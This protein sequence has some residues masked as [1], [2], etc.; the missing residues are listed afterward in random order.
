MKFFLKLCTNILLIWI[1]SATG[2]CQ[3]KII[4]DSI[5][6]LLLSIDDN[7]AKVDT[8][9]SLAGK[10][11]NNNP[12]LALKYSFT[13]QK[14]AAEIEYSAGFLE[15]FYAI[16][17]IYKTKGQL[18]SARIFIQK[19][20]NISEESH[21][22]LE[23]GRGFFQLGN[24]L[25]RQGETDRAVQNYMKAKLL[26]QQIG[27]QKQLI[28]ISNALGITFKNSSD[29]DSAAYYYMQ[30]LKLCE[31]YN[32]R[33]GIG[34]TMIN[35][36][37]MHY[38]LKDYD[39]ARNYSLKSI[40]YSKEV[41]NL[42][43]VALAYTN[44]GL[45]EAAQNNYDSAM[46]YY[47]KALAL[48][49]KIKNVL[50]QNNVFINQGDIFIAKKQYLLALEK[51]NEAL[52][53]HK[54][55]GYTEGKL[56]AL[57]SKGGVL[58][59]LGKYR[60]AETLLDSALSI[61]KAMG[62]LQIQQ[63]IYRNIIENWT[64]QKKYENAF[65]NLIL[66]NKLKDSIVSQEE[67][68]NITKLRLNYEKEKDQARILALTN[69]NLEKDLQIRK[70]TNQRNIYLFISAGII[71]IAVFVLIFLRIK[72]RNDNLMAM[73]KIRQLEKDKKLISAQFILEGQE[74]ERKRIA[75]E[76]H[77]G[78]G[79]LLSTAKM[80]FSSIDGISPDSKPKI[81]NATKLLEM[82]AT[83]VRKITHNMMPG[84][85]SKYGFF[86]AIDD[87]IEQINETDTIK[88]E[89]TVEGTD[90]RFP[91]RK[92]FM[93]YRI[94]QEMI[95]NTIKHA[96]ASEVVLKIKTEDGNLFLEYSDNGKGFNVEEKIDQKSIGL[97][98]IKS[99]SEYL[100]G[101][102]NIMSSPGNGTTFKLKVSIK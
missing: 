93:L 38:H 98:S 99:R 23:M 3:Q 90:E 76:L 36:G 84:L 100:G 25:R 68:N 75:K 29:Y 14:Q 88:A 4:Q 43:H 9:L 67:Q 63:D 78:I 79:V 51:Y 8:L 59:K 58:S 82:A 52:L 81:N 72:S 18:D 2:L 30:T 20:I 34:A 85:L 74:E 66:Q 17:K 96:E 60:E 54:E 16:S 91:E 49:I 48:Y 15:S 27:D 86:E 7:Q 6:N 33:N 55:I 5:A 94:V 57:Y 35:L 37:K 70:R 28:Y 19:H 101:K 45:I 80:Q 61:A 10:F 39:L 26:F 92:E 83:E 69:E 53:A 21:D 64:L 11:A 102:I 1:V 22:S 44:L 62:I 47:D 24:I 65:E 95:N 97:T 41:K 13:A 12:D 42:N 87:L 71:L 40:P 50:G 31:E 32:F 77:D 73:Q 56:T 46:A 89:M